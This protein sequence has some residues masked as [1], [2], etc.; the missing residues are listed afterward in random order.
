MKDRRELD[1]RST[2]THASRLRRRLAAVG[3]RV[4][5]GSLVFSP[6]S[7]ISDAFG[8]IA[9]LYR[10]PCQRNAPFLLPEEPSLLL[11]LLLDVTVWRTGCHPLQRWRHFRQRAELKIAQRSPP[12]DVIAGI[13]RRFR[14]S[15]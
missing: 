11:L 9:A 6:F 14:Q 15:D 2:I 13:S 12:L 7:L 5:R 1:S 4:S 8:Q 10:S 3:A